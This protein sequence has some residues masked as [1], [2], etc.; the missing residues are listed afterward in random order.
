M[1]TPKPTTLLFDFDG[2]I[3]D[4][5]EVIRKIAHKWIPGE[6]LDILADH[7][8]QDLRGKSAIDT[9][10]SLG[11][12]MFKLPL[13]LG[14]VQARL[15]RS[16]NDISIFPHMEDAIRILNKTHTMGIITSNSRANVELFLKKYNLHET[17][18]FVHSG[19]SVFGKHLII[20]RVLKEY[21]FHPEKT[22]YI[23]DEVRDIDAAHKAGLR[24]ISVT[25]GFNT[26]KILRKNNP[27]FLV[28]TPKE[29]LELIQY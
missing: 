26:T 4:T 21:N 8:I 23:G 11:I 24:V 6:K 22:L 7:K 19:K 25:W 17:F 12:P 5:L 13:I 9:V 29:L 16:M 15:Y 1:I 20:K 10:R 27:D 18:S 3:G 28:N 2:T 14:W